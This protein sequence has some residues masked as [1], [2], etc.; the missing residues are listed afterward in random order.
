[1]LPTL[2]RSETPQICVWEENY[3][4]LWARPRGIEL[5]RHANLHAVPQVN[6][7]EDANMVFMAKQRNH[8]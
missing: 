1:M 2:L 3:E 4:E 7:A 5:C 6:L 8:A